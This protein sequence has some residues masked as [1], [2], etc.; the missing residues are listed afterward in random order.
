MTDDKDDWDRVVG[1]TVLRQFSVIC[2]LCIVRMREARVRESER[3]TWDRNI[4][5]LKE[6]R[7]FAR[8]FALNL[9]HFGGANRKI[10]FSNCITFCWGLVYNT[11]RLRNTL[12][13]R[14]LY[15][16]SAL[17]A[18]KRFYTSSYQQQHELLKK[19]KCL[20][21]WGR[22]SQGELIFAHMLLLLLFNCYVHTCFPLC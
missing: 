11:A 17:P 15:H 10:S 4:W 3:I 16:N 18:T 13:S 2:D 9:S 14:A 5:D 20:Q 19:K 21:S 12:T 8:L 7:I 1:R 6:R 22:E